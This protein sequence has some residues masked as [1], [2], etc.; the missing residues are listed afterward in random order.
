[1]METL[2]VAL[3]EELNGFLHR[4]LVTL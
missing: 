2:R 3:K 4:E 1:V